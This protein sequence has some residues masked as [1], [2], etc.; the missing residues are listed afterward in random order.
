MNLG[1]L[2]FREACVRTW[3]K[4]NEH[5]ILTRAAAVSFYAIA[6]LVPFL[7]LVISL[8]AG[9]F[10]LIA[11][12]VSFVVPSAG[13]GVTQAT[14]QSDKVFQ[15]LQ[16]LLPADA[17]SLVDREIK[18]IQD[19]PKTGLVSFGVAAL[20]WLS[21]SLFVAVMDAMNRIMGV[22]ETRPFWRVRVTAML[23]TLSQAAILIV[24]FVT[25]LAWPQILALIGLKTAAAALA[26]VIQG[27][28][29]FLLILLSFAMAMYFGPDAEQRWEWITPGSL[30][31]TLILL[32][33]S[34]AFRFYVQTWGNYSATYGSL[35]GVI[36]LTSWLWITSV[37]LLAA[38]EF[39]KVIE[40]AS[41]YGKPYGQRHES[42]ATPKA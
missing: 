5:E 37:V 14:S 20:I 13:A 16:N 7:A 34:F 23:M 21:S 38:A 33:V 3:K 42:M 29:V 9:S 4:M 6:A 32:A 31:G 18:T 1:G 17:A 22:S 11:H 12:A 27:V 30:A 24:A 40:D 41:P 25:T 8:M 15:V 26:S 36:V 28:A 39:D 35:A 19:R 10:P 2:S